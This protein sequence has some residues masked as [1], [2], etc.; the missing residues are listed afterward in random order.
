M[1]SM[2]LFEAKTHLSRVVAGLLDGS[3]TEV[4]I[5]RHGKPVA[6]LTPVQG[7]DT[8]RRIGV[9]RGRIRVPADTNCLND[10]VAKLFGAE[11]RDAHSA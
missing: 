1:R 10:Q 8:S 11:G 7:T 9:A 5:L 3:E 2:S 4:R 6:R